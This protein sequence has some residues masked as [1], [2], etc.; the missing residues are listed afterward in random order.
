MPVKLQI[1]QASVVSL[2]PALN[3]IMISLFWDLSTFCSFSE[4][5]SFLG[6]EQAM[7]SVEAGR[8]LGCIDLVL[9]HGGVCIHNQKVPQP[10]VLVSYLLSFC[11]LLF[12]CFVDSFLTES[13]LE[14]LVFPFGMIRMV[15]W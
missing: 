14:T 4:R 13:Y 15:I 5:D 6:L 10:R 1:I 12:V 7:L 11:Q 8:K 2:L 9:C 3:T